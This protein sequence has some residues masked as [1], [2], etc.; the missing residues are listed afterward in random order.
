[1]G[2][3]NFFKKNR[4][5]VAPGDTTPA[6]ASESQQQSQQQ[7]TNEQMKT[8]ETSQAKQ[9]EQREAKHAKA[10]IYNLI[11]IDESGSMSNLREVTLSGVNET[12]GTIREAQKQYG[13][14]QEHYVSLVTFDGGYNYSDVRTIFDRVPATDVKEFNDYQPNGCTPLLDAMGMSL[15]HL[16]NCIKDDPDASGV[17]TVL[18]DGMENSSHEWNRKRVRELVEKLKEEGW[19]FSY[20]GSGHD[21]QGVASF[22]AIDNVVEFDH[23]VMGADNTWARSRSASRFFYSTINDD[24]QMAEPRSRE[25]RVAMK[26]RLSRNYYS[27]R[28]TPHFVETLTDNEVFV[29]GSDPQGRHGGGAAMFAVHNF[30]ARIGVGEGPQGQSYAIPTTGSREE[31]EQAVRRFMAYARDNRETRFLVSAVGCGTAGYSPREV[32]MMFRPC[33]E[34]E[35]VSLPLEFWDALGLKM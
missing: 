14:T 23:N 18:T 11:I 16:Y 13:D 19:T 1:M 7:Q 32:A 33:V 17:V 8:Q 22:L 29:F 3:A 2:F 12:L 30:G 21:V 24:Y 20:M 27:N 5:Q 31:F 6:G 35:N 28:V 15:T 10:K 9:P 26:R 34:M 4:N 25:E